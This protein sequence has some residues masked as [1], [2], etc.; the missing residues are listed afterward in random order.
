MLGHR[1][2]PQA[3]DRCR[4]EAAHVDAAMYHA[5]PPGRHALVL[6]D[7]LGDV[8]GDGDDPGTPRHRNG[9]ADLEL[10]RQMEG[11]HGPTLRRGALAAI[12]VPASMIRHASKRN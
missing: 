1:I 4:I 10:V 7:V 9:C 2:D 12:E 3:F 6:A 5:Q 11:Y 8:V